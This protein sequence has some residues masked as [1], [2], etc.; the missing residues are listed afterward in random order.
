M[1]QLGLQ[2]EFEVSCQ[3]TVYN[4]QIPAIK[5]QVHLQSFIWKHGRTSLNVT[6]KFRHMHIKNTHNTPATY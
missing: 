3:A 1:C 2:Q 4:Q 5:D 6:W